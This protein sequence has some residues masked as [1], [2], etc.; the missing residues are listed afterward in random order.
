MFRTIVHS[1]HPTVFYLVVSI[2]YISFALVTYFIATKVLDVKRGRSDHLD[3]VASISLGT[4]NGAYSIILGFILFLVWGNFQTAMQI[5]VDEGSK[6]SIIWESSR[7]LP[8]AAAQK[9]QNIVEQYANEVTELEWPAM[10]VG[11]DSP[12]VT[13]TLGDMYVLLQSFSPE[14]VVA[15]TFYRNMASALNGVVEKRNHRLSMLESSIPTAW[16]LFVF[17]VAC[18]I[19]LLNSLI[20]RRS[21]LQLY[22][23]ILLVLVISFFITAIVAL[24]YPFSGYISVNKKELTYSFIPKK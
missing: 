3:E 19:I 5:A 12:Q 18:V 2:I 20:L 24:S 4:I 13:K 23:H 22:T 8:P 15:Q 1:L 11:E 14:T 16:Y 17:V 9:I 21:L 10:A 7:A 6:L